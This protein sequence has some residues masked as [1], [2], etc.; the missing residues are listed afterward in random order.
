MCSSIFQEDIHRRLSTHVSACMRSDKCSPSMK[1][2][3][4]CAKEDKTNSPDNVRRYHT[5]IA[6]KGKDNADC[7]LSPAPRACGVALAAHGAITAHS[8]W[9][10]ERGARR[11]TC[12]SASL[13]PWE[14]EIEVRIERLTCDLQ[15]WHMATPKGEAVL[16]ST[17]SSSRAASGQELRFRDTQ[18]S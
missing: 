13:Q 12:V 7:H 9:S 16:Y 1:K 8:E 6:G 18:R 14:K 4:Q 17:S 15:T 3:I 2:S 5:P 11:A 10:G